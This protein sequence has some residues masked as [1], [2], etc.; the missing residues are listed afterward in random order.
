MK[1][2]IKSMLAAGAI[3]TALSATA[4]NTEAGY[5]LDDYTYRFQMNPAF[6]NSR[7]FVSMPALG[8]LNVGISGNLGVQDVLYNVNGK[9][10]TFMHPDVST[11]EAMK[12]LGNDKRFAVNLRETI[13]AVGFKGIG[14]YN[15]VSISA[16]TDVGV[17]LPSSIFSFLKEGVTNDTYHIA[18]FKARATAFAEV[19]L[20]HSREIM[21]G[22]RVGATLKGL[23]GAGNARLNLEEADLA[24]GTDDWAIRS[25]GE[26]YVNMKGFT[27]DLDVNDNTGRNYSA[28]LRKLNDSLHP[29]W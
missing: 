25:R 2:N 22:L 13:L 10:V 12:N 19:A 26:M 29:T 23:V 4:Q 18:N 6:G 5:F 20:N 9:T 14:G 27:Y 11:A 1:L 24:L 3:A 17:K 28:I 21:P 15:T 8:N 7:G 16:R